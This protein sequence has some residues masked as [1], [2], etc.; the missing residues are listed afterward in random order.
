MADDDLFV[1]ATV[2]YPEKPVSWVHPTS[3][4]SRQV[5]FMDSEAR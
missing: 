2:C 3:G 5:H 4:F 1:G